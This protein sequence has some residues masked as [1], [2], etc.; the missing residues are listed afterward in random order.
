MRCLKWWR[1]VT[2]GS[3]TGDRGWVKVGVFP[4]GPCP[5][6]VPA[7]PQPLLAQTAGFWAITAYSPR[8]QFGRD[9]VKR[10]PFALY[11]G[12]ADPEAELCQLLSP[13]PCGLGMAAGPSVA[14]SPLRR[15][16]WGRRQIPKSVAAGEGGGPSS[17]PA[18]FWR[19]KQQEA[20]RAE[21][22][23]RPPPFPTSSRIHQGRPAAR[24]SRR[25]SLLPTV[26]TTNSPWN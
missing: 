11:T 25:N 1:R 16:R 21:S 26:A 9:Q 18:S 22:R 12:G 4:A 13:P 17:G 15:A 19:G 6:T 8:P 23:V 7:A 3:G 14:G 10:L 2:A 20:P 5:Q 24:A